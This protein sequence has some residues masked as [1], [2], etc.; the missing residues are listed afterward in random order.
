MAYISLQEVI[1]DLLLL[2]RNNY[3]SE[4]EDLSRAQI[5]SWVKT[6]RQQLWR[7]RKDYLRDQIKSTVPSIDELMSLVDDEF[8][9]LKESGPHKLS[10]VASLTDTP[11]FTK[12]TDDTFEDLLDNSR[13]SLLAV[14]DQLGENI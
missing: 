10:E 13:T 8:F 2:I 4:S 9:K 14:H 12:R 3:I 6:Y 7:E 5:E 11:N 1:D